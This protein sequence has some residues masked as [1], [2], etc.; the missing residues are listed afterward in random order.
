MVIV[1]LILWVCLEF[2]RNASWQTIDHMTIQFIWDVTQHHWLFGSRC[3]EKSGTDYSVTWQRSPAERK[4]PCSG[5]A[6]HGTGFEVCSLA[7][8]TVPVFAVI[9][10][11]IVDPSQVRLIIF[12]TVTITKLNG[13][14]FGG[15]QTVTCVAEYGQGTERFNP[16][17]HNRKLNDM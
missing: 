2:F 6:V 8:V 7:R 5:F 13:N 1:Y 14:P 11:R 3:F 4:C 15:S 12:V 16:L 10:S 17:N 9:C